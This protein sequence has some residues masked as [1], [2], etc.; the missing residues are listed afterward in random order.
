MVF[1]VSCPEMISTGCCRRSNQAAIYVDETQPPLLAA[2][3]L[4]NLSSPPAAAPTTTLVPP[5]PLRSPVSTHR[6]GATALQMA[7][8][9]C[10]RKKTRSL[11]STRKSRVQ[12]SEVCVFF[13]LRS[14]KQ[15]TGGGRFFRFAEGLWIGITHEGRKICTA[16]EP[17]YREQ[18]CDQPSLTT[19]PGNKR[20]ALCQLVLNR[21]EAS[22]P[23]DW[24]PGPSRQP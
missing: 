22:R 20:V 7:S 2:A 21:C 15:Q 8:A 11:K 4:P 23:S 13:Y 18:E 10:L 14:L 24:V 3:L 9:S 6:D 1:A 12:A 16:G 17:P 5:T 19:V